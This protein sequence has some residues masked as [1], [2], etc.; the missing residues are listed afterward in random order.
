MTYTKQTLSGSAYGQQILITATT[1]GS[2]TLIHTAVAGTTS[3]DE[4]WLYAYNEAT[5]SVLLSINWGSTVEPA[6]ANRATIPSQSGR[7][8]IVDGKLL[9]NSLTVSAYATTGSV[10]CIDGFVNRIV[11]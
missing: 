11:P 3:T 10:I 9:C 1:S 6:S 5:A 4:I 8:L 2:A 7:V